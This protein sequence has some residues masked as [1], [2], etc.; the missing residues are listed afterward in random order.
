MCFKS[1]DCSFQI[2]S[3]QI[4]RMKAGVNGFVLLAITF[5]PPKTYSL[6]SFHLFLGIVKFVD[7]Y[8]ITLIQW[9]EEYF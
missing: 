2:K 5:L 3:F 7:I 4:S 9:K 1:F 8:F 6:H